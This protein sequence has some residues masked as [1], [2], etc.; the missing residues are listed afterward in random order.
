MYFLALSHAPPLLEEAMAKTPALISARLF[1]MIDRV[2]V[3]YGF[4]PNMP[5]DQ[6]E[7]ILISTGKPQAITVVF[8]ST[9]FI[10][11]VLK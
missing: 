10:D 8:K 9:N 4:I 3:F 11:Y 2:F 1:D 5:S 6:Q 7:F